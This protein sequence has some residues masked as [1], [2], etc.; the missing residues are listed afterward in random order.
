MAAVNL[1]RRSSAH[2]P[3]PRL[4]W[5]IVGGVLLLGVGGTLPVLQNSASTSRGFEVRDLEAQQ[6]QLKTEISLLEG[7]VAR[8]TT[9]ERIERR[10]HELGLAPAGEAPTYIQIDEAG[11]AP[12]QIPSEYL[13]VAEPQEPGP[14]PGW[15]SFFSK[16]LFWD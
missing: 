16:F 2:L 9:V 7:D 10:A 11:P 8:L 4:N 1:P 6:A 12:A 5:W 14:R 13:P 15:R 3:L